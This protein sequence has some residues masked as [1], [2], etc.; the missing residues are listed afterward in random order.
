MQPIKF[1][2]VFI[3]Q[4]AKKLIEQKSYISAVMVLTIGIEIMGGFFD[5]KPLK[6]PKQSK[7]RFKIAFEKL[8]GGRYA[9][10]NRNDFLYESLRNQ[11]IHSLISGKILLFSLEKQHL[12]EQDGF[13]I[14]NPLTFLSDT[15]KASKKLAEMF[16]KGKVFTKKIPDNALNLSAFI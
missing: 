14:F 10:I 9:A 7:A 2:N 8:L 6:S 13:I 3:V 12:T 4:H 11:L 16:V 15:E 5:K 1:I